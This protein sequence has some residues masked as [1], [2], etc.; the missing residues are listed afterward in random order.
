MDPVVFADITEY[1]G[2]R[3]VKINCP[4]CKKKHSHGAGRLADP[5]V[6]GQRGSHC[7]KGNYI[8]T[9]VRQ[10]KSPVPA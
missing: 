4:F 8:L 3:L 5:P 7:G 10:K 1:N 6:L 9:T 2:L